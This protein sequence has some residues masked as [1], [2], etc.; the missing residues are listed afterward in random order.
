MNRTIIPNDVQMEPFIKGAYEK[1]WIK[2]NGQDYLF[3]TNKTLKNNIL[4][5]EENN[6]GEVFISFL[7]KKIG[8]NCIE[9]DFAYS[10][11]KGDGVISKSFISPDV[12]E[13]VNVLEIFYEAKR[14]HIISS[15]DSSME[16]LNTEDL[17]SL[18]TDIMGKD[19]KLSD[20]FK[21]E[22]LKMNLIDFVTCQR[23]RMHRNI[24][25]LVKNEDGNNVIHLAPMFDNGLCFM[26]H[27]D[28]DGAEYLV[29]YLENMGLETPYVWPDI[30]YVP[31]FTCNKINV[32]DNYFKKNTD[33]VKHMAKVI[34][35]NKEVHDLFNKCKNLN[36]DETIKEFEEEYDYKF[37]PNL[38]RTVNILFNSKINS[39]EKELNNIE[40]NGQEEGLTL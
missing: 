21:T 36:I 30:C 15:L 2:L 12:T 27:R 39:L 37:K 10:N 25:L 11:L 29:H 7:S 26:F 38:K 9:A 24:E 18:I 31:D 23:D 33:I 19:Y 22:C 40:N 32:D 14:Q 5:C 17:I 34:V 8:F 28:E 16:L 1:Y 13:K 6:V 4:D 3:K 20:N 35:E